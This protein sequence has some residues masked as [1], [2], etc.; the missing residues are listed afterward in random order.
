M[1]SKKRYIVDIEDFI[2]GFKKNEKE[3]E[4]ML[5][6]RYYGNYYLKIEK[7]KHGKIFNNN[8]R[9]K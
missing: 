2:Y 4:V 6:Y 5:N 8:K 3:S 1:L 9:K 7:N